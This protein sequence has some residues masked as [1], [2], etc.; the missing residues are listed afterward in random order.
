MI[1]NHFRKDDVQQIMKMEKVENELKDCFDSIEPTSIQIQKYIG[2]FLKRHKI[3]DLKV[4]MDSH[5]YL[6]QDP[7]KDRTKEELH[8]NRLHMHSIINIPKEQEI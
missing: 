8:I 1:A 3:E 5:I 6:Q 2:E 7:I 4:Q